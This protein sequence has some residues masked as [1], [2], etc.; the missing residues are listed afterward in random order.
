M[1]RPG[2]RQDQVP[3]GAPGSPGVSLR[4]QLEYEP[5]T[6]AGG[7]GRTQT[8]DWPLQSLTRLPAAPPH[9]WP[10][11]VWGEH[12]RGQQGSGDGGNQFLKWQNLGVTCSAPLRGRNQP[13]CMDSPA[14][15]SCFQGLAVSTEL[16]F[17]EEE[18]WPGGQDLPGVPWMSAGLGSLSPPGGVQDTRRVPGTPFPAGAVCALRSQAHWRCMGGGC[19]VSLEPSLCPRGD[20]RQPLPPQLQHG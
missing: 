12:S 3:L 4:P 6:A 18:M 11:G 5:E 2:H 17:P 9:L 19:S 7:R 13:P 20:V 15:G 1:K 10:P 16:P 8:R 14:P